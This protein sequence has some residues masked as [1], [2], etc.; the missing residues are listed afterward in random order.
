RDAGAF[1]S[2]E[3]AKVHAACVFPE[4][5]EAR[6]T[7]GG[8]ELER[9]MALPGAAVEGADELAVE[10]DVCVAVQV[11][12]GEVA[13]GLWLEG[14]AIEDVAVGLVDVFHAEDLL[15]VN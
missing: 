13:A 6:G 4:N 15:G 8:G 14:G 5:V 3:F 11:V 12:E 10:I 9:E 2:E 1:A 7:S